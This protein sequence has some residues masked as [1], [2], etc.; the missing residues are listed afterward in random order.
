MIAFA[1]LS[2]EKDDICAAE[3]PTTPQLVLRFYDLADQDETKNVNGLYAYALDDVNNVILINEL[4]VGTRDSILVPLR[5]DMNTTRFVLHKE[6]DLDDNGTPDDTSDDI[7]LGNPEVITVNYEREDVFVSRACGY[8]TVF[9]N[10]SFSVAVDS[11]N[12]IINSEI[13]NP[14]VENE[15]S[16]HVKI[17]H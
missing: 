2:C 3:T 6:F 13:I 10:I 17:F 11:D 5:S 14:N 12:W 7:L 1:F 8:K 15:N 9:N 16:A 4:T